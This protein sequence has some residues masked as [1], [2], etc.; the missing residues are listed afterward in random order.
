MNAGKRPKRKPGKPSTFSEAIATTICNRLAQG[1][2][3]ASICRDAG[4]PD[5]ST[6]MRW[7]ERHPSFGEQYARA[8]VESADADADSVTDIG[9][10]TLAGEYDPA[11]ARVAIDALKWAAGKRRPEKYGERYLAQLHHS[12]SVTV[13]TGVPDS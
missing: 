9:R 8:R 6:I 10:R 12:G 5:Y 2:A 4:M 1:E 11:A 7:C 3:L 13:V